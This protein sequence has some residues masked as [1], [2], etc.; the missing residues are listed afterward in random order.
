MAER[1]TCAAK[2]RVIRFVI[3]GRLAVDRDSSYAKWRAA[4]TTTRTAVIE[5]AAAQTISCA[6][7]NGQSGLP[8]ITRADGARPRGFDRGPAK[9]FPI[10]PEVSR[11]QRKQAPAIC[12][13][14][15]A[16]PGI[17]PAL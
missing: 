6:G 12:G 2:S 14:H 16:P 4:T 3:S 17:A 9:M 11:G 1:D 5:T 7:G 10:E 8:R 15:V 13:P